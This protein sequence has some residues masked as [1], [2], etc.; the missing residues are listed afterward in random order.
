MHLDLS[1]FGGEGLRATSEP[2]AQYHPFLC[3]LV[4]GHLA[5]SSDSRHLHQPWFPPP[6]MPNRCDLDLSIL[7][8]P[9]RQLPKI[10]I[11]TVYISSRS[12]FIQALTLSIVP[13][14]F[15]PPP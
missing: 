1:E 6:R 9:L 8:A 14:S 15:S 13:D 12:I 5:L 10:D 3:R 2:H 11:D 4:Q 7:E